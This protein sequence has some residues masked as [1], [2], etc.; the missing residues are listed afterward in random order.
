MIYP[1]FLSKV[2]TI[3]IIAPSYGSYDSK[4]DLTFQNAIKN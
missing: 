2:D 1:K 3:G 4:N